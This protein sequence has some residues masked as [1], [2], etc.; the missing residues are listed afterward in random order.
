[1]IHVKGI[2][3]HPAQCQ[4]TGKWQCQ[5]EKCKGTGQ[6]YPV[7][8][9]CNEPDGSGEQEPQEAQIEFKYCIGQNQ[10]QGPGKCTE[11]AYGQVLLL[12]EP[13]QFPE[14]KEINQQQHHT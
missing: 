1:V 7:S 6:R 9:Y 3:L 11:P 8:E 4:E 14:G 5:P 10:Q 2:S 13:E 12:K